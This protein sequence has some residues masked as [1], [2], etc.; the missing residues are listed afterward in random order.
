MGW[1]D[2][3]HSPK[4]ESPEQSPP[5]RGKV[6]VISWVH[7]GEFSEVV[8]VEAWGTEE[9]V[10][11]SV[12]VLRSTFALRVKGD[13]ME[14]EFPAGVVIIVEPDLA[15]NPGDYVVVCSGSGEATFKQ[16]VRDGVDW[17]LKPINERY[18]IKPLGASNVIGVVREMIKKFR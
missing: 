5:L 10:E 2:L 14:P 4:E 18:P 1:L 13:S 3:E 16:L 7:A 12:P 15:P 6:P 17:Y 11:T 9:W 8:A